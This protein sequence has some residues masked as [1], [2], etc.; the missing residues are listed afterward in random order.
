MMVRIA[1]GSPA[2]A[3]SPSAL[4][5]LLLI[6]S[7]ESFNDRWISDC[8]W[9][10]KFSAILHLTA[11]WA[12]ASKAEAF[13]CSEVFLRKLSVRASMACSCLVCTIRTNASVALRL[14]SSE[15]AVPRTLQAMAIPSCSSKISV[16]TSS[17]A[18]RTSA[19]ASAKDSLIPV[20]AISEFSVATR[21]KVLTA[22]LLTLL[23]LA[24]AVAQATTAATERGPPLKPNSA[25]LANAD[26]RFS[27]SPC[28]S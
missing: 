2:L 17:A 20:A 19:S 16:M 23:S 12:N 14:T 11:T 6:H 5:A 18:F 22:A 8:A 15:D 28:F 1:L 27:A 10:F 3:S 9:D 13:T 25:R 21:G 24:A 7:L 26:K 4:T